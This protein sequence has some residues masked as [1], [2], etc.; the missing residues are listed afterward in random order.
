M[1]PDLD[2]AMK[3]YAAFAS[4]DGDSAEVMRIVTIPGAPPSKARPRFG[5]N[6][7]TYTPKESR[8]AEER[9]AR[10]L[11]ANLTRTRSTGPSTGNVFLGCIFYRPNMQR[12][13]TDN[14]LKHVCDAAN[15]LL[16][17]DDCQVTAI[18][19][20]TRLDREKPRTIIVVGP[21]ITTMKRGSDAAYPCEICGKPIK[22]AGQTNMKKTCSQPCTYAARG[23]TGLSDPVECPQCGGSFVRKTYAQQFCGKLCADG[24]KRSKRRAAAQPRSKCLDC[25][26]QLSHTRGGRCRDCWKIHTAQPEVLF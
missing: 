1:N 5:K 18:V 9:T 10:Y 11:A 25:G 21:H 16:W 15:G 12:I 4:G 17:E 20:I 8:K 26:K 23:Y 19:G 6:G 7:H 2:E 13:D 24:S 3:L 14:M 22:R